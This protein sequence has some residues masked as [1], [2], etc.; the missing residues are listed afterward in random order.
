MKTPILIVVAF[1]FGLNIHASAKPFAAI[2]SAD[3]D[4]FLSLRSF[5]EIRETWETH[6]LAEAVA[7]QSAQEFFAPLFAGSDEADSPGFTE[8]MKEEFGLTWDEL[9]KLFPGQASLVIYNL[10]EVMLGKEEYPDMAILAE[11][12]GSRERLDE[13][14]NIQFERNAKSHKERNPQAEHELIKE[15]F[16]GETLY[17]DEAFDGE[18]TY[19]EDGYALVDGIFILATEERLRSTVEAIIAG[20]GESLAASANYRRI[21]EDFDPADV[22]LYINMESLI[23]PLNTAMQAQALKG[24]MAMF[25]VSGQSLDKALQL[26]VLKAFNLSVKLTKDGALSHSALTYREKAGILKLLA[27]GDGRLPEAPYVPEQIFSSSVSLFDFSQMIAQ[28]EALIGTASPSAPALLDIQL[29]NVKR[30]TGVDL[31]SAILQN[32]EPELVSLAVIPEASR[33]ATNVLEPDQLLVVKIK[34]AETLSSAVEAIMDLIPGARAQIKNQEFKGET[35]YTIEGFADPSMSDA[36]VQSVSYVITRTH[37]LFNIGR[38]GLLQQVLSA[39]QSQSSGFWQLPEVEAL[40]DPISEAN[41]V[42]RSYVDISQMMHTIFLSMVEASQG[43][44]SD[45]ALD[46]SKIPESLDIPFI[47]VTEMNEFP[48]GL[49]GRSLLLLKEDSE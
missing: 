43:F 18:R 7:D 12:S 33:S 25:G 1:L 28:I 22:N 35:I 15:T 27:Y 36:P 21:Y 42:T 29:Q 10:P 49:F 38:V 24:G 2:V 11:F 14:M 8:V 39:M 26:G 40:F 37:L 5:T 13:L 9:F 20:G 16:M 32:F 46:A 41:P 44:G 48:D 34:D 3:L 17:F 45:K 31:R 47:A 30:Q 6:P 23:P 19:I 4:L